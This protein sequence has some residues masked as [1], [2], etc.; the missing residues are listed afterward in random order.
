LQDHA[1]FQSQPA[2]DAAT[3]TRWYVVHTRSRQEKY[4]ST[5]LELAGVECF[6]PLS[7][8]VVYY[9]HRKRVTESPVFGCYLFLRG[10]V[11]DTYRATATGRVASVIHVADQERLAHEI[12]QL[13][14]AVMAGVDLVTAPF[15]QVGVRARVRAGPLKGLEGIVESLGRTDRLTLQVHVLGRATSVEIDRSLL[16]RADDNEV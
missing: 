5:V 4:L 10:E 3:R 1:T 12:A 16:D 15:L 11:E 6:L 2:P 14:H 9:G 7:R 13:R 8:R